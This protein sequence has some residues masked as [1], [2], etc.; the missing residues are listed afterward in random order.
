MVLLSGEQGVVK[1]AMHEMMTP[2]SKWLTEC[3]AKRSVLDLTLRRMFL[4]KFNDQETM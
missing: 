1:L 2:L 3:K 4:M